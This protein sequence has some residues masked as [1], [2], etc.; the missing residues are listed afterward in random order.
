M[1]GLSR[2]LK[3][4]SVSMNWGPCS[5][6]L[7]ITALLFGVHVGATDFWKLHMV[8]TMRPFGLLAT[9][10]VITVVSAQP[11]ELAPVFC[12]LQH[13]AFAFRY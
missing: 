1:L 6:V 7:I 3:N 13:N 10:A 12:D 11:F 9:H 4:T 5:G 2:N 8:L